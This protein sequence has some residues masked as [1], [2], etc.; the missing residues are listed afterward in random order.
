M[1]APVASVERSSTAMMRRLRVVLRDQRFEAGADCGCLLRAGTM[2][3]SEG[4]R[5]ASVAPRS[6]ESSGTRG[7]PHSVSANRAS[8]GSA[9]S[10]ANADGQ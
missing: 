7:R 10:Q 3:S 1:M 6:R 8:H 2:T 9:S 5:G 4:A